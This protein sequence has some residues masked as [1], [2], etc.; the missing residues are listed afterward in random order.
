MNLS[1]VFKVSF[2]VAILLCCS[3]LYISNLRAGLKSQIFDEENDDN[4]PRQTTDRPTQ[5][6]DLQQQCIKREED[7][8][9][10]LKYFVFFIGYP[11][12]GSTLTGSLLDAHPNVIIAN[13][14]D[15]TRKFHLASNQHITRRYLFDQLLNNSVNEATC[16]QRSPGYKGLFNY[17]V[18]NQ[19]QGKFQ[20]FIQVIG[21]KKG[22]GNTHGILKTKFMFKDI[23]ELINSQIK[24]IHVYRNPYDNIAT[25]VLRDKNLRHKSR[26]LNFKVYKNFSLLK[27]KTK[28]YLWLVKS[29]QRIRQRYPNDVF[30]VDYLRLVMHPKAVIMELCKFLDLKCSESYLSS[31]KQKVFAH[32][33]FTRKKIQWTEDIK[34]TIA[35]KL[36]ILAPYRNAFSFEE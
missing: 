7:K 6:Q 28:K 20:C 10:R 34:N 22:A 2:A 19:W 29:I 3:F 15:L 16:E 12:S 8:Y 36:K 24:F 18:P 32:Q 33:T 14:Y 11:R 31:C 27:K 5:S 9:S 23:R 21:D 30:D 1:F 4:R 26:E 17:H 35:N 13:E 25:M